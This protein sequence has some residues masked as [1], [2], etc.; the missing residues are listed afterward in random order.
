MNLKEALTCCFGLALAAF[1][2]LGPVACSINRQNQIVEAI[3]AGA[4]PTAAKCAVEADMG[5]S[6]ACIL[7]ASK[8][9]ADK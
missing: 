9:G 5:N 1:V 7:V 6:A 8:R 3:K 2:L 4:D